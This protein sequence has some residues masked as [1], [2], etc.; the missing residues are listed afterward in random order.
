VASVRLRE[1][2]G[3]RLLTW[4]PTGTPYTDLLLTRLSAAGAHV[5]PVE[6]RVTGGGAPAEL[7]DADAV[8]LVPAGWPQGEHA[9]VAID[10]DVS[11]PLLV[12]WSAGLP[13]PAVARLRAG[14]GTA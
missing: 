7:A 9:R 3:E 2:D 5:E 1:L 10:D 4:S 13:P 8:A 14:M 12:L 11:L 6:A